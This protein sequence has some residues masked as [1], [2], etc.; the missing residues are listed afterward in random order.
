MKTASQAAPFH[1]TPLFHSLE[2][3]LKITIALLCLP[4]ALL[5]NDIGK[6]QQRLHDRDW[7]VRAQATIDLGKLGSQAVPALASA[8]PDRNAAVQIPAI[9]ALASI[10]PPAQ[11]AIP[12]LVGTMDDGYLVVR[13]KARAALLL[14]DPQAQ[15]VLSLLHQAD[16]PTKPLRA[17]SDYPA[18]APGLFDA[19]LKH[20]AGDNLTYATEAA[21]TLSKTGLH[22]TSQATKVESGL[23]R[24]APRLRQFAI[25]AI[26]TLGE[27]AKSTVPTLILMLG[28]ADSETRYQ[29]ATTLGK[30]GPQAR[31]A[32]HALI[33]TWE[34]GPARP[35]AAAKKALIQIWNHPDSAQALAEA[36]QYPHKGQDRPL[37]WE[38][39]RIAADLKIPGAIQP[40]EER[41]AQSLRQLE[42]PQDT[43]HFANALAKIGNPDSL[44]ILVEAYTQTPWDDG[45][46]VASP[47]ENLQSYLQRQTQL[48]LSRDPVKLADW[49]NRVGRMQYPC[50]PT[51]PIPKPPPDIEGL[52]LQKG[53]TP[54]TFDT[55]LPA[56]SQAIKVDWEINISQSIPRQFIFT[57][58]TS[59]P[60][61]VPSIQDLRLLET[62]NGE[63]FLPLLFGENQSLHYPKSF[64]ARNFRFILEEPPDPTHALAEVQ[65]LEESSTVRLYAQALIRPG[66]KYRLEWNLNQTSPTTVTFQHPTQTTPEQEKA[67]QKLSHQPYLCEV[68]FRHQGILYLGQ[69]L[70]PKSHPQDWGVD[71]IGFNQYGNHFAPPNPGYETF[72]NALAPMSLAIDGHPS[73]KPA[74]AMRTRHYGFSVD[75]DS[76]TVRISDMGI[77]HSKPNEPN[78]PLLSV[79]PGTNP[80]YPL[81]AAIFRLQPLTGNTQRLRQDPT[82]WKQRIQAITKELHAS[83]D[84]LGKPDEGRL[85]TAAYV[86]QDPCLLQ[87]IRTH[88]KT[89][90]QNPTKPTRKAA[91]H[92]TDALLCNGAPTDIPLLT[93]A[94]Q[95]K[96]L[97]P[98]LAYYATPILHT[99]GLPEAAPLLTALLQRP[100]PSSLDTLVDCA[101]YLKQDPAQL[102]LLKTNK[103]WQ[104]PTPEVHQQAIRK[105]TTMFH[106]PLE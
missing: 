48:Q 26:G 80:F 41:L 49:W 40:L 27:N 46:C 106:T 35:S 29:A 43:W 73:P 7:K 56:T 88:L 3:T 68:L 44:P 77:G 94:A 1:D 76:P 63:E 85:A 47:Q 86:L 105:I 16:N 81:E 2:K 5:G 39:A 18:K 62:H 10:G 28:K 38:A 89:H 11:D 101:R 103:K 14:I 32:S 8:L 15:Q 37:S 53:I 51:L 12:A 33:Q 102:G 19:I 97:G 100:E 34:R 17:L 79:W 104:A 6:L 52:I 74:L 87:Q 61:P 22:T 72:Q 78:Q 50:R 66:G 4:L 75:G 55:P 90:L 99:F 65:A 82:H 30:I 58:K 13:R 57:A 45:S 54:V 59:R 71:A 42:I 70:L 25:A 83:N 20:Y 98:T 23:F 67:F 24:P 36:L 21:E 92:I 93:Q 31:D 95:N 9:E 69:T 91:R 96:E 84:W 64:H 60:V